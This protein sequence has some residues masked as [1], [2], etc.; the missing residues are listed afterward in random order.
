[1]ALLLA[2]ISTAT[3]FSWPEMHVEESVAKHNAIEKPA[4]TI[5]RL[6]RQMKV[7]GRV[8]VAIRIDEHGEVAKTRIV[9]GNPLL[10]ETVLIAIK[11]WKFRPFTESSG[12]VVVATTTL[13]FEF[14]Q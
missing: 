11:H 9:S 1:M 14:K 6:A 5:S 10:V 8:E 12:A 7:S 3:A 4:P 2:S 13:S